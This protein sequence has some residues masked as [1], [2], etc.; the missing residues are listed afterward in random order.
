MSVEGNNFNYEKTY[1][2][3][4]A[5]DRGFALNLVH[6]RCRKTNADHDHNVVDDGEEEHGTSYDAGDDYDP[7]LIG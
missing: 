5:P 6:D 1:H 3:D 4:A 7:V 2:S